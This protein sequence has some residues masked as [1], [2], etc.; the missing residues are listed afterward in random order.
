MPSVLGHC[1]AEFTNN[2]FRTLDRETE[3]SLV[4]SDRPAT[5]TD[6]KGA[7]LLSLRHPYLLS[8]KITR[9]SF[10]GRWTV[11]S[12]DSLSKNSM[13]IIQL[14]K[15]KKV[16]SNNFCIAIFN[17]TNHGL[18]LIFFALFMGLPYVDLTATAW[19]IFRITERRLP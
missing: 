11:V 8:F 4:G 1:T 6:V 19:Y 12:R 15:L 7:F 14:S 3:M 17:C 18:Q 10:E 2:Q 13:V 5:L 9:P 16:Y